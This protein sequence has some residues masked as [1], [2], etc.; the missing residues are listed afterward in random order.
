MIVRKP[1]PQ[2]R[3]VARFA[4]AGAAMALLT[5]GTAQVASAQ[6]AED[7]WEVGA[8]VDT[9][10]VSTY[11]VDVDGPNVWFSHPDR[12]VGLNSYITVL[13]SVSSSLVRTIEVP[14]GSSA[15]GMEV[16]EVSGK[17]YMTD[18]DTSQVMVY[19]T[20]TYELLRTIQVD[21]E[22]LH[23]LAIDDVS[24]TV[25][26]TASDVSKVVIIDGETD[27]VE[28]T[29]DTPGV[30]V[31]VEVDPVHNSWWVSLT[32]GGQIRRYSTIDNSL[33]AT[34]S[35]PRAQHIALDTSRNIG[36]VANFFPERSITVFSLT[37]DQVLDVVEFPGQAHSIR[38]HPTY[39]KYFITDLGSSS[40]YVY[41]G[42]TWEIDQVLEIGGT[43]ALDLDVNLVTGK[44]Y[45]TDRD[46][47]NLTVI[48]PNPDGD[49]EPV[50]PGGPGGG[51]STDVDI[52]VTVPEQGGPGEEDGPLTIS[53]S[54]VPVVLPTPE[55]DGVDVLATTGELTTVT[56]DDQR[57]ADPG[58]NVSGQVSAF[59]NGASSVPGSAL[60]WTPKVLSSASGQ[61]V[62]A[63][64]AVAP[65]VGIASP[66][67]LAS[68]P[69]G[70]GLGVAT[71][72]A[73]LRLEVPTSTP[74][75]TY[76]AVLTVTA[77]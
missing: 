38:H 3:T 63:G 50:D 70:A 23:G 20:S 45:V 77:I 14:D 8:V 26:V 60:G 25:Y 74:P 6:Q 4:A 73:G 44:V 52:V 58:W 68:A 29:V 15:I 35:T 62:T 53:A 47:G 42:D 30:P 51:S 34:I 39:N 46:S 12:F 11:E 71:L 75:G 10:A 66:K 59:V 55:L 43:T 40:V 64:S 16:N 28:T 32:H 17:A 49:L 22:H 18:S 48:Q 61:T 41:D 37:T 7:D 13:D 72:G 24:N 27:T 36:V 1:S 33:Q 56:V 65:G 54:D 21:Q 31:Q 57:V 67:T 2:R 69:A 5:V 9:P 76:S 19:D